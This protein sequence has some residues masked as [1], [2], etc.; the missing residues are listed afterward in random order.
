[1]SGLNQASAQ[2]TVEYTTDGTFVVPAG[3]NRVTVEVWGAGAGGDN[4]PMTATVGG[5]GGAFASSFVTGL[6][7]F[8]NIPI[9]VGEGGGPGVNGENSSFGASIV[10]A[11]GGKFSSAGGSAASSIGDIKFSGGN[12]G[13]ISL[14]TN[15]A[16]FNG[17]GGG[18]SAGTSSNG[19]N[20]AGVNGGV[21]PTGGGNGGSADADVA[22]GS[23]ENGFGPGGGGAGQNGP[24]GSGSPGSGADG[25]VRIT[26]PSF[27]ISSLD[28]I[29]NN[30]QT[31]DELDGT[32]TTTLIIKASDGLP[33]LPGQVFTV[34]GGNGVTNTNGGS[35]TNVT[36]NYC[37][38]TGCPIG[39]SSGEYFLTI[40]VQH[41]GTYT[42][43]V[44]GPDSDTTADIILGATNCATTY[45]VLPTFPTELEDKIC[46]DGDLTMTGVSNAYYNIENQTNNIELPFGFSQTGATIAGNGN[47]SGS[48]VLSINPPIIE[49]DNDP[50]FE[51]HLIRQIDGCRVAS[52]KEFNVYN[53]V[54]PDLEPIAVNC[55]DPERDTLFFLNYLFGNDNTGGGK[56]YVDGDLIEDERYPLDI[57]LNNPSPICKEATYTITDSCGVDHSESAFFQVTFETKPA[58]TFDANGPKSPLCTAD[59]ETIDLVRT[60]NATDFDYFAFDDQGNTI[61]VGASSVTLPAPDPGEVIKYTICLEETSEAPAACTGVT[62]AEACTD[63]LCRDFILYQDNANCGAGNPFTSVCPDGE[64]DLCEVNSTPGIEFGCS[65]LTYETPPLL[66]AEVNFDQALLNCRETEISGDGKVT[67]LGLDV[68]DN[69]T[70]KKIKDLPGADVICD[71]L[72]FKVLGWRP[73]GALYDALGCD[74]TIVQVIFN[75][76]SKLAGGDG[77]GY[78]VMADTDGDGAFDNLISEGKFPA[79]FTFTIPNRVLGPGNVSVRAVGGWVNSPSD[80]CGT[81]GIEQVNL[82]DLLPIGAIPVVGV[83]IEDA[84]AFA[85]CNINLAMSVE[86]TEQV[87]VVDNIPAEYITCNE[88]GYIFS[89]TLDCEIPVNWS[90]PAAAAACSSEPLQFKGVTSNVDIDNYAGTET[91]TPVTISEPGIYQILGPV[92]GSVLPPGEYEVQY[93]AVSCNGY[94][95]DC[96]FT[97]TVTA[98]DPILECPDDITFSASIDECDAPVNGLAPYQGMGCASIINYSYINPVSGT[99]VSTN[100]TT[101]GVHNVPDGNVFELGETEVTY[102]MLVDINGDGDYDDTDETQE[103]TFSVFVVDNQLPD[104]KCVDVDLQLDNTGSGTVFAEEMADEIFIDGGSTDNCDGDLT[105]LLSEDNVNYFP[106]LDFDCEDIGQNVVSLQVTDASD[107]VSYC[108]AVVNVMNF[109]DGFKLDLDVPEICFEPFQNSIDFSPYIAIAEPNGNNIFHENVSTLG[110]DVAGAFGISAFLPDPGSTDDPGTMTTDGVYTLGTG[111]GWISISYILSIT[112]QVNQITEDDFLEGCFIMVHD[113]FRVEKLDPVWDGGYMCC[114]QSPV[115]LGG[116]AWDGTGDPPVPVDML[117]L[118]DIRGSYPGD[119]I[120]E[121]SGEGV[122]FVDPDGVEYSGDEFYMFDPN[123]LDG[124]YSLT[125]TIGDEPCIFDYT[126]DILVTCQDLHVEI[127]D[128]TVCPA[129][130]VEE[131]EVLVNFDDMD[132]VVSTTGFDALGAA[133]AHYGGGPATDPVADLVDVPVVDGRVVIPGFYAPAVR[134]QDFE[135]C[136]TTYQTTPFGC[137]DVFCYTI[138]VQDLEAPE[139]QNCPK[140]PVVVDAPSGWCQSFVNFEYPWVEDNCMGLDVDVVQ[141]DTTGLVSGDLFPVGLTVLA[142]TA[143]DTVGN[144]SY[145]EIKIIVNDYDRD[146][147]I[148]C[149]DDVEQMNDPDLCGAVVNNI[150]PVDIEDNCMDNVSIVYEV[151]N[152]DGEVIACGLEDASGEFFPVGNNTVTYNVYD[153]PLLLITEIVQDGISSGIEV[154]N[155]GPAAMDITCATFYLKNPDGTVVEQYMVPTPN[156]KSTYPAIPIYPPDP[157]VWDN[158]TPNLIEVG[159]TFVYTFNTVPPIG[160]EMVYCFAFLERTI[161]E[162]VINDEVVGEVILRKNVCDHDLQSDFIAATPCDPGS[163][164]MLNPGLPVMTDNGTKTALQNYDPNSDQCSFMVNVLDLEDPT[165]IKHDSILVQNLM[166]PTDITALTCITSDI[167]MPAGLVHDVNIHNLVMTIPDAGAVTAYLNSPEGTRIRLFDDLCEGEADVNVNLD[168]TIVWTPAPEIEDALCGPL[169]QG[170]IYSPEESFMKFKGEEAGGIWTLEMYTS[171]QVTGTLDS[172]DLEILYQLPY[173]QPDVVLPNDPLVCEAEFT[174]IHPIFED[175]CCEGT[176]DVIYSFENDVTGESYVIEEVIS[177]ENGTINFEGLEETR[178]FEV[179]VTTVEYVLTDQYANIG[180]CSFTVTV[181]DEEDPI[182]VY[183]CP[184][185]QIFLYPGECYGVLANPPE[186]FDNCEIE[187]VIYYFEDGSVADIMKLPIGDYNLT[188]IA[189]DIYGNFSSCTFNVEVVEY[190]PDSNILTCNEEIN[191]SLDADCVAE[192]T[193]DMILEGGPYRCY[194]NYC[195]DIVD[196][197]GEPHLNYF[198]YSDVG[199]TFTVTISECY[200]GGNECW[201]TVTI[202]EKFEPEIECPEDA[203]VN[204]NDEYGPDLL[205]EVKILNCEPFATIDYTDEFIDYGMCGNPRAEVIRTWIVDDQQGNVVTCDQLITIRNLELADV[206]FPPNIPLLECDL[207]E[208][209]PSLTEPANTGYPT[210]DG[211]PVNENGELCMF[212]FLYTDEVY[213]YCGSSF[214]ILRTWKVR[215]MCGEVDEDNPAIHIQTIKVFDTTPPEFHSCED[216]EV[217]TTSY[218]CEGSVVIPV[219]MITDNCNDFTVRLFVAG[220]NIQRQGSMADGTLR[221]IADNLTLGDHPARFIAKDACGNEEI[222]DFNIRVIDAYGP[223][224]NCEQNKQATLTSEGEARIYAVDFDSGSFDNCKQVWFKVL[225]GHEMNSNNQVV[226]DGGAPQLNGDD[227]PNTGVNDV[228]FDDDVYF[229]CEDLENPVMVTMRVFEVDPGPGPVDPYR[230]YNPNGDLYGHFN[231]CWSVVEIECKIPPLVTAPDITLS[232]EDII[233]PY[234]SPELFPDIISIC[235]YTASYEDSDHQGDVCSGYIQRT[236][237]VESCGKTVTKVQRLFLDGAEPFDP[238]TVTFPADQTNITCPD[239]TGDPGQPTWDENPCNIVTAEIVNIDTFNYVDD[240][241]YKIVVDWAIVDW[242]VYEANTGAETNLDPTRS[243]GFNCNDDFVYDG[244]YR[245][246]QVLMVKDIFAPEIAIEDVCVAVT[247]GCYAQDV[248]L[249]AFATDSCNVDQKFWWKYVVTNMDTWETVQYSYNYLPK[250]EEGRKGNRSKD[251][252]DQTSQGKIAI[253]DPLAIGNYRVEW[254]VGDGC[255]N[256]NSVYQY[257]TVADKKPP[258]PFLVDISTALM[259]NG[260]VE[261]TARFFDKGACNGECLASFDDCSDVIYFTFTPIAPVITNPEWFDSDKGVFYFNPETGEQYNVNTGRA[262]YFAGEAHSFDPFLNTAGKVFLCDDIPA[263]YVDVYVWDNP[264][265]WEEGE[266]DDANY[267]YG[268]VLLNLNDE[269]DCNGSFAA[270]SGNLIART[271]DE[272]HGVSVM[273]DNQSPEYPRYV[274]GDGS[275]VFNNVSVNDYQISAQK[276]NNY[277]NGVSTLDLV[278][279]QR[280]ILGVKAFDNPYDYI[281]SDANAS[282]SVSAS[283]LLALR[284]LILGR[285]QSFANDSWIFIEMGYVFDNEYDPWNELADAR[286]MDV[287]VEADQSGLDFLGI[288]V[289]DINGSVQANAQSN[290]LETRSGRTM[291]LLVD[292]QTADK[293][294]L[295]KI[296]VK[297][298]SFA[299][300]FGM[301]FTLD[302]QGLVFEN[303][304][305]GQLN[306]SDFNIAALEDDQITFS[307]N[308][309]DGQTFTDDDVL[310]TLT[311]TASEKLEIGEALKMG[312][313]IT[314]AEIY[315]S[316]KLDINDLE[317]VIRNAEPLQYALY[318]NEPNPF[319][320][321][322]EIRFDLIAD[323]DYQL[324]IFDVT[325]KQLKE[326][327]DRGNRGSNSIILN[328]DELPAGVLYYQLDAGNF[329]QNMKMILIR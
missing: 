246:T 314:H 328:S 19:V 60:S 66:T 280:H 185:A 16:F 214:E 70:G 308:E 189:T 190:I 215:D 273:I 2:I 85:G 317:L 105:I 303:I 150:A 247:N 263:V 115:W 274:V 54:D 145:C 43:S 322:T 250:P 227:N 282:N 201:G 44:D 272:V 33:I 34:V 148:E 61:T 207:V 65:F 3:I 106:S 260:M 268:T 91:I 31:P 162:V 58:F 279:I 241:C 186:V 98:G 248:E 107:N 90:I 326:I 130:W 52:F 156:N 191:V 57:D 313:A 62:G 37:D 257:F 223:V 175:N 25:L 17:G 149:P 230:M 88:N 238:C 286:I 120:G 12:G 192:L 181:V 285:T 24:N 269:G 38:G 77:G 329:S 157:V 277:G 39:V 129:N 13:A 288:K 310:F 97:V 297:A 296:P 256:A 197:D 74:D 287:R 205:G 211:V 173:D 75:L 199:Q 255:G 265:N 224:A 316:E 235:G 64:T 166:V 7:P 146:P 110:P 234:E 232:C 164:D 152:E 136:V 50:K 289:G 119:V 14:E 116:A 55:L 240:A 9:T 228:W 221:F 4:T 307:W 125:Y 96:V 71:V 229:D 132:L 73:L 153:Q 27:E 217:A 267:D 109:F 236:W 242:C 262:K 172:W 319:N 244:Y 139:F 233:D 147:E 202:M 81:M 113:V 309:P 171:G 103:C 163:F 264:V 204:C 87:P 137:A 118:T 209:D 243:R 144:Q 278:R 295:V 182:F 92:P 251:N 203:V 187:S 28:C 188:A 23:G 174:W 124:T 320:E 259:S 239:D 123:G 40:H 11:D 304:A 108:K 300:V 117:S 321:K 305:K 193:A 281:A 142:Y 231:D 51:L 212:S 270:V 284:D 177:N 56:F 126:Q 291:Q 311:F 324:T 195:I 245:Y 290:A 41:S 249:E 63:T 46:L 222:C 301:Q 254:I 208:A 80:V 325:G 6:I 69:D 283:D 179:G 99:P 271:N 184:D 312:S 151:E 49:A 176:V 143:T 84:L 219:P 218:S 165:C 226:Y 200:V 194:E 294:E 216:I 10:L 53:P 275:Y 306:V 253:L 122:S 133:G 36:F 101:K 299:D 79:S 82:L 315:T 169:G 86:T 266:C 252:L 20:A 5:G 140:E 167:T 72:N 196:G 160:E 94:P 210:I 220:A 127:S 95:S 158:P 68:P 292:Q 154:T 170:G 180:G 47:V 237:T 114:D 178:I 134:N 112:E 22:N 206:E 258:T 225:R 155:F 8:T 131:K 141:V 111:T 89:Q 1:M 261:M 135:I 293:G 100:S 302:H 30:D 83:I 59:D 35:L 104:A 29:C 128:Y 183:G 168:Q 93:R 161:D 18:S 45:P 67:L 21:A 102:T 78:I 32:Y 138:T 121:W 159:G 327:V 298:K 48:S 198:D 213:Q 76:L 42:V 15:N 323:T 26:Y 318:Q 276:D